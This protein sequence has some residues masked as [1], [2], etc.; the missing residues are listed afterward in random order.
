MSAGSWTTLLL[1]RIK[2]TLDT[3]L[4]ETFFCIKVNLISKCSLHFQLS[5]FSVE[6]DFLNELLSNKV[7]NSLTEKLL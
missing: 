6:W 7:Y 1:L 2:S 5:V 4:F 3:K